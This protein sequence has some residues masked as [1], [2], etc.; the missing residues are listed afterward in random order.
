MH[1]CGNV[2]Y[3]TIRVNIDVRYWHKAD[4][5]AHFQCIN[6]SRYDSVFLRSMKVV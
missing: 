1:T 2:R 5:G 6:F 3:W 4:I